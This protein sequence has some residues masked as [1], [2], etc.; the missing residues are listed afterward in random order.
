MVLKI[1]FC[2]IIVFLVSTLTVYFVNEWYQISLSKEIMLKELEKKFYSQ[3][4][5]VDEKKIFLLG[6]SHTLRLTATD[7][8]KV[9]SSKDSTLKI[10]N[11]GQTGDSPLKR[12]DSLNQIVASKPELVMYGIGFRDFEVAE[13]KIELFSTSP[14]TVKNYLPDPKSLITKTVLSNNLFL[15]GS[16]FQNP[17]LT[18]LDLI[19][20]IFFKYE[21]K[22]INPYTV[23]PFSNE[24]KDKNIMTE[25]E[26]TTWVNNNKIT[27][28]ENVDKHIESLKEI[29]RAI[30]QNNIK[31]AIFTTPH[32]RIF[33]DAIPEDSRG[34]FYAVLEEISKEFDINIYY[35]H[36]KYSEIDLWADPRHV[37]AKH[38]NAKIYNNDIAKIILD[39]LE[40]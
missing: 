36:D 33:L 19:N 14:E 1:I 32:H 20:N 10:Y 31:I 3:K 27:S 30:K 21:T 5:K 29:I 22:V 4:F 16:K 23:Y 17:K 26:I 9:L 15:V 35:L 25:E 13:T 38:P 40:Q 7:I 2:I 11:L 34:H 28:K 37:S 39:E 6:S 18:S 24:Q 8:Q 12:K